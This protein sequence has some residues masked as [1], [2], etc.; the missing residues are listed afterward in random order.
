[1]KTK[2]FGRLKNSFK[3]TGDS[4]EKAKEG[5]TVLKGALADLVSQGISA[6]IDGFKELMTSGDQAMN[7]FKHKLVK[8]LQK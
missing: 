1:M 5:F 3:A 8:V 2:V 6:A 7:S 4:A